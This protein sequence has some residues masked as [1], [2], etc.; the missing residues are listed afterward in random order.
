M[1]RWA[2]VKLQP[3]L[4]RPGTPYEAPGRMW[5]GNLVRWQEGVLVPIGGW[6]R[7]TPTPLSSIIRKLHSWRSNDGTPFI[8]VGQEDALGIIRDA[9]AAIT[10][11]SFVAEDSA[12]AGGYGAGDYSADE[13]GTARDSQPV[14]FQRPKHWTFANFGQDL[15][16][17]ASQDG[18][19][20]HWTPTTGVYPNADVPSNAPISNTACAVTAER[21]V[22][23]IGAGGEPQ[24][25]A[26]SDLEDYNGWDFASVTG[27]AGFLDLATSSPLVTGVRVKDGILVLSNND[28]F[29][30]RYVGAPYWYGAEKIAKTSFEAPRAVAA[31]GQIAAWYGP[32]GFWKYDGG[33]VT[34]LSC[35]LLADIQREIDPT[36]GKFRMH[37]STNGV[38]PEIW[39]FYPTAGQTECDRYV[40]WNFVDDTWTRGALD[41][42]AMVGSDAA[43]KPY[44][45][46]SAKHVYQHEDGWTNDGATRVGDVWA[47]TG[48][49]A[50]GERIMHVNQAMIAGDH[51]LDPNYR[52]KF[53]SRFTPNGSETT[54]GPY[55]P[56]AD[57][58]IDARVSGRDLRMRIEATADEYWSVGSVRL[59]VSERGRR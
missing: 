18:R 6:T 34:P 26:W 32:E 24:R 28:V 37:A 2:P 33:Q 47:E 40:V 3:G 55:S 19:L 11:T 29:I 27:A 7:V 15:L 50:A 14:Y 31:A 25:V 44:A 8:A 41:R 1:G 16:A 4:V 54:F 12:T 5:D 51:N 38:F 20:L 46:S 39:F 42:T 17:V 21:A 22:V 45:A 48:V 49:L 59:L 58:Y 10:P 43:F 52:V 53:F 13:Y 9:Y 35:P 36:Y 57:G 23:L 56:R 30:L